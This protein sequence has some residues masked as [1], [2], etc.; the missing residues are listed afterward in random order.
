MA[1]AEARPNPE[2]GRTRPEREDLKRHLLEVRAGLHDEK[3][4]KPC[5]AHSDEAIVE[6]HKFVVAMTGQ[7]PVGKLTGAEH[8]RNRLARKF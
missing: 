1:P 6:R 8:L 4:L 3:V 2:P 5:K 7:G